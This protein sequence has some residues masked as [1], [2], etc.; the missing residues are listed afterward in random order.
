MAIKLKVE[1]LSKKIDISYADIF[2]YPTVYELASRNLQSG[3]TVDLADYDYT[4]IHQFLAKPTGDTIFKNDTNNVLLLG[5]NGFV[6][7]HIL[8]SFLKKDKGK[9]KLY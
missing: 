8:Y 4:K 5:A 1:L 7:A 9:I 2:K 6:G 3:S